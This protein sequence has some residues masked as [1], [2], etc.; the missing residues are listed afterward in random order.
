MS[1]RRLC[2]RMPSRVPMRI[3]RILILTALSL[4]SVILPVG[5]ESAPETAGWEKYT[6][7]TFGFS[8]EYPQDWRLGESLWNGPGVMLYP[9][10]PKSDLFLSGFLNA[11]EIGQ[12]GGQ[13][14][15]DLAA[16]R[17]QLIQGQYANKNISLKW[18]REHLIT[19]GGR[20]AIQLTFA[21]RDDVQTAMLEFHIFSLGRTE[22]R[23][24]RIRMPAADRIAMM[25]AISR[26][27]QS[28]DAGRDQ[29]T[30]RPQNRP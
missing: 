15:A 27:L 17:R 4:R 1:M 5:A 14:L 26:V 2:D 30:V 12:D 9:P 21:Y 13:T 16:A 18:E 28:Y 7:A 6:D 8:V 3:L 24:V 29:D 25:P 11:P 23:D 19:L 22:G 20:P 10:W